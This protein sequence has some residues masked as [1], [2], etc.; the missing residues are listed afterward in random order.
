[1][2]TTTVN[3]LRNINN[4]IISQCRKQVKDDVDYENESKTAHTNYAAGYAAALE[5]VNSNLNRAALN[6]PLHH[7]ELEVEVFDIES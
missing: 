6:C 4:A 3:E 5:F 1:M 7:L 2:T